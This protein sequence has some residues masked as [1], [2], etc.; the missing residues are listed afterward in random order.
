MPQQGIWN[1]V[2]D[3]IT[4]ANTS[5]FSNYVGALKRGKNGHDAYVL[6]FNANT[7]SVNSG[8]AVSTT[9]AS[10][11]SAL[12]PWMVVSTSG[13]GVIVR[14]IWAESVP[15]SGIGWVQVSGLVTLS[16]AATDATRQAYG[17]AWAQTNTAQVYTTAA[18]SQAV[19]SDATLGITMDQGP[20]SP[21]FL[22]NARFLPTSTGTFV[23]TALMQNRSFNTAS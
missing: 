16:V 10:A 6:C 21:K 18:L 14:G 19:A 13:A 3:K 7:V 12:E 5:D 8:V 4:G 11:S 9:Q 23:A 2:P 20:L 17:N 22:I 1:M 15:A